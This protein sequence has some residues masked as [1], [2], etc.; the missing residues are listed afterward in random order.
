MTEH[1]WTKRDLLVVAG[2]ISHDFDVFQES[3]RYMQDKCQ[4]FF[5]CGNHEAWLNRDNKYDSLEKIDRVYEECRK[6][7][8]LVD[9]CFVN[10]AHSLLI[11]PIQSWYDGSL[12][13]SEELSKG[14]QYWPW[15]DFVRCRWRDFPSQESESNARI[16]KGLAEHCLEQNTRQFKLLDAY[17]TSA[18]MTVSHFLPNKQ[19]L[20]DWLD[21]NQDTFNLDW[22]DHGAGDMS[23]KFS[24]VAGSLLIDKQLRSLPFDGRHIHVFGHSHRPKDFEY[25][26]IRY[27]HHPL[28]K[29]RERQLHMINPHVDFKLMWDIRHGEIPS[30]QLLRYWDEHGGGR[31]ALRKRL[32]AVKPGRY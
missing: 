13:F 14:F 21:L 3:I 17:S 2:D 8:I 7:G 19:S 22:L 30:E 31:E 25:Q 6:L 12:S 9:S 20:P 28:G 26:D 18:L 27:I 15:V 5:V 16:P 32:Q 10:G 11:L 24:K 4:V 29:P 1:R 23:A